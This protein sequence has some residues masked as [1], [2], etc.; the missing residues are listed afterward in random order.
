MMAFIFVLSGLVAITI[1]IQLITNMK[2]VG[3]NE[4]GVVTGSGG[5]K[6]FRTLSGGRAFII[7]LL[8]RFSRMKLG[9]PGR[10]PQRHGATRH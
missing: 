9:D 10:K 8:Q 4:L 1:L 6:G 3:G 2:I 5:S 7:P